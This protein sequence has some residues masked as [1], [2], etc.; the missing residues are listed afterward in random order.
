MIPEQLGSLSQRHLQILVDA[1]RIEPDIL[2]YDPCAQPAL[3]EDSS[4]N[5]T[6]FQMKRD[7]IRP[8]GSHEHEQDER[9]LNVE[10]TS[11]DPQSLLTWV[12]SGLFTC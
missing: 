8:L 9:T 5:I 10:S 12:S 7:P 6:D 3:F 11:C 4:G 1:Y 2:W